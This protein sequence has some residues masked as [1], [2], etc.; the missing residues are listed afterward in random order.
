MADELK[1]IKFQMMLSPS[2]A[3]RIDDWG[4]ERRIRSRAEAIRRLCANG[5]TMKA[6]ARE[7][8]DA[9]DEVAMRVGNDQALEPLYRT[10]APVLVEHL[11]INSMKD[12]S[13]EMQESPA[14]A[15]L[16]EFFF[17]QVQG[18]GGK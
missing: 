5:L 2:E 17:G 1:T 6:S 12:L 13:T 18:G 8:V 14:V 10:L 4:F 9:L 16:S 7:I 11:G 3:G 15:H